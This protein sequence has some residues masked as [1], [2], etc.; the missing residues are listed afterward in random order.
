[1]AYEETDLRTS[2]HG[3]H[4]GRPSSSLLQVHWM[5]STVADR[6]WQCPHIWDCGCWRQSEKASR[7]LVVV[8]DLFQ[9]QQVYPDGTFKDIPAAS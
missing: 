8:L 5:Q 1:M 4:P 2:N 9:G 7:S 6:Q 3:E